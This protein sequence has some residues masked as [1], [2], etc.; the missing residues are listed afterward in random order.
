MKNRNLMIA[1]IGLI[2]L[3]VC[4]GICAAAIGAGAIIIPTL[5]T[6]TP[7]PTPLSLAT[8]T[9]MPTATLSRATPSPVISTPTRA[10]TAASTTVVFTDNYSGSCNLPEGD[11]DR[12]TYKCENGE[13]SMLSKVKGSRW[14]YYTDEYT[15]IVLEADAHVVSGPAFIEYGLI[16]RAASDGKSFYGFTLTREG[17]FTIFFC[18]SPCEAS[19]DFVDLISYTASNAVKTGTATN[20]LKVVAQGNQLA[21]Y[22]N[23]T[24]LNTVSDS[25]FKGGSVGFFVNNDDANAKVAFDNLRVSEINRPLSLPTGVPTA[26]ATATTAA[27]T[28]VVFTDNFTSSCGKP[29]GLPEGDNDKR[30]MKC[31]NGEY[32]VLSKVKGSRWFYYLNDDYADAVIEVDA[33]AVSGPAFNEYGLVFRLGKDGESFYGA[34]LTRD[35][36]YSIFLYQNS[37]FTDLVGYTQASA[38][39]T[40]TAVNHIK[41]IAQA[42]QI[43][44]Y[45]ND[46]WLNT[47]SDPTFQTGKLG[48]FV[49]ND[50]PNAKVAFDNLRVSKINGRLPLPVPTP[51]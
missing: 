20:R 13:Y 6:P 41:V 25:T 7:S 27:S 16:F 34:S 39:K 50:D 1:V 26:R 49:N 9:P 32:T 14:V 24:W 10:A 46:T 15:D 23:D 42:N 35:G 2:A 5:S 51:R 31:E 33:R 4:G 19:K 28:S 44:L 36:R 8:A 38:I 43:A 29:D 21:I 48:L 18:V 40:G 45:V 11:N 12:R 37:K 47:V 22:V 30:T 3:C 17:K